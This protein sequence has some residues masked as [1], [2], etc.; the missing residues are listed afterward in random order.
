MTAMAAG[1]VRG[2]GRFLPFHPADRRFFLVMTVLMWGG[3]VSGFGYDIVQ[4][5][6][7]HE[8]PYPLIVHFHAAAFVGW[9]VFFTAQVT[10]IRIGRP[11]LH[12]RMGLFGLGL[13]AV[14]VV[15]GPATGVV[16]DSAKYLVDHKPPAFLAIQ[17]SD[18]VAFA[19]LISAGFLWR[20]TPA[21]HKRLMLLATLYIT[22]AGFARALG[23]PVH[24]LLGEGIFADLVGFYLGNDLLVLGFGAYD[25]TTRGRL[26]PAYMLGAPFIF[27]LQFT[28]VSL[29]HSPAWAAF[30]MHLIGR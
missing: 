2:G 21:A 1:G 5:F 8:A 24:G 13:A 22:D 19:T 9:M 26:H 14:M 29:L 6:S 3:I 17:L 30:S 23:G 25:L 28:A 4:H 18:I 7:T 12:R 16:V 20:A 11:D 10:A 27:A 15:L